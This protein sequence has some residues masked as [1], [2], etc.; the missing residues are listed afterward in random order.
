[1]DN[2]YEMLRERVSMKEVAQFYGAEVNRSNK[3]CCPF[4]AD[5]DPSLHIY[6][7]HYYCFGCAAHGD[8]TDFVARLFELSQYEAA[9]KL[10]YDLG[11]HLTDRNIPTTIKQQINPEVEYRRWLI[12]AKKALSEYLN[13]LGQ[14]RARYQPQKPDEELHPLFVESL[15]KQDYAEYLYDMVMFGSESEQREVYQE[16]RRTVDQIIERMKQQDMK[17]PAVKRKAI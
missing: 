17:M 2:I 3:A 11:L 13:K 1:M 5:S 10:D 8:V 9:K 4:H 7:D 15:T 6:D 12:N 14:W 16:N